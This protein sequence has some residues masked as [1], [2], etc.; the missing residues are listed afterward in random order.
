MH[1]LIHQMKGI[2]NNKSCHAKPGIREGE[3]YRGIAWYIARVSVTEALPGILY[4]E[5]ERYRGIAWYIVRVSVTEVLPGI[6]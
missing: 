4:R 5:G 2:S 3:R 6:S 1:D